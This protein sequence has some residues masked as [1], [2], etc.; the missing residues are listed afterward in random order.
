MKSFNLCVKFIFLILSLVFY[1]NCDAQSPE[2]KFNLDFEKNNLKSELPDG[3]FPWGNYKLLKDSVIVYSGDYSSLIVSDDE[4][5]SFGSIAYRI[6]ARYK[7]TQIVLEGYMKT[8]NVESGFAGLLLRIDGNGSALAFDNMRKQNIKGTND[9]KKYAVTLTY[10][11]GA[12]YIYVAGILAGKGKAWFDNFTLSIDGKNIQFLEE[13][14]ME[15]SK[16]Q[17]DNEFDNGSGLNLETLTD[18]QTNKL[19]KLG[20]IWG[21]LKYYH[22]LVAKGEVNWD[23]ELFRIL[24]KVTSGDFNSEVLEWIN[25]LGPVLKDETQKDAD[26]EVK[27][28]PSTCWISD[29]KF[30]GNE[31][32][33][34]LTEINNSVRE[35]SHYYV[36]L[37]PNVRNPNF[38]NENAY[39]DMHWDDAGYRLLALFRYWNL[40]EYFFP[41]KNLIEK[42]W[43]SVLKEYIAKVTEAQN[44]L[45]YKLTMLQ[46]IGEIHDTHANIWSG[47]SVLTRF[48]GANQVPVQVKII[49]DKA[50]VTK[51]ADQ[52]NVDSKIE[53]GDIIT[54]ING[55]E[56]G[57]VIDEK[58][59]YCPA[60]NYPRKLYNVSDRILRTNDNSLTLTL[61]NR[62][63]TYVE[64][65]NTVPFRGI[66]FKNTQLKSHS[67]INENVGYIYPAALNRGEIDTIMNSFLSKKGLIVDLRC[68]PSDFIVFSLGRF[69][70]SEP[71]EF[72]KFS[73]ASLTSPGLFT[74]TRPLKVGEDNKEYFRGKVAIL[75]DESTLSQAEYTTMALRVAPGAVVIGSTTAG[76]DGNVSTVMLPG[77]IRTMISGIGVYYPDGSETQRVGIVPDIKIKPTIEAIREGRDEFLEKA[78]EIIGNN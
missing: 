11:Q 22:P 45:S 64:T 20:K 3:W 42:D 30:I 9:W 23:Y 56:T 40:I 2:S 53:V 33:E 4:G 29:R 75:V 49:E 18:E 36:S 48:F 5:S 74:F 73:Q 17:Q 16:V 66:K 14:K 55:I 19:F 24:P 8:E 21:F 41:Y 34:V 76:A 50:V 37:F 46:L 10:P 1:L 27:L 7:G 58:I 60:S 78:L 67:E 28:T 15:L 39:P 13:E 44:E 59:K 32:S 35:Y 57:K 61:E 51:I 47:D 26:S 52:L 31:L 71:V 38:Q 25:K 62:E 54:Q 6:P 43:D 69:L 77:N 68:Y 63:T 65:V 72:V 70:M 12:E